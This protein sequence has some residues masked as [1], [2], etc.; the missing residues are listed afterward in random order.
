MIDNFIDEIEKTIKKQRK[1][2][3]PY[4]LEKIIFELLILKYYCDNNILEYE[5]TI[6]KKIIPEL[7]LPIGEEK[8][9]N[10]QYTNLLSF[11]QYCDLKQ[12]IKEYINKKKNNFIDMDKP[13]LYIATN[14]NFENYDVTGNTTYVTDQ[15]DI[16]PT[17]VRK[18]KI[19]DKMLEINNKYIELKDVK[20]KDYNKI[21]IYDEEPEYKFIK[22]E[23]NIYSLIEYLIVRT[24]T[25][26]IL[27]TTF[28]KISNIKE[29]RRILHYLSQVLLYDDE[30]VFLNF[31]HKEN[32]TI[33]IINY[34]KEKIETIEKLKNIIEKNRKQEDVLVKVTEKEIRN[35]YYRIGFKLYQNKNENREININKIAEE[36][37]IMIR[38]LTLL[39]KSI[40]EEI[41][42]LMNR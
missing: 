29:A 37:E 3:S 38:Q 30:T 21:I 22:K 41:N 27:Q 31:K 23:N 14:L 11:I 13:K 6:N 16:I 2:I 4:V 34:N 35:N 12:L 9:H 19:L 10:I 25:N 40:Q 39:D 28:K 42:K 8:L 33:S 7:P 24:N 20:I 32:E 26:I 5:E 36:N 1:Y 15:F 17:S 18:F